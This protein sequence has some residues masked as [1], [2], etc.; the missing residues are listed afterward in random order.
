MPEGQLEITVEEKASITQCWSLQM[1]SLGVPAFPY[2]IG[3][4]YE[5][6]K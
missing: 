6:Y 4:R 1:V 2:I 5:K 3:P